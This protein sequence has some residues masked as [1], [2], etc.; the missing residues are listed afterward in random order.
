MKHMPSFPD[1]QPLS[2]ELNPWRSV[3][4]LNRAAGLGKVAT[5]GWPVCA[6]EE[7]VGHLKGTQEQ[8]LFIEHCPLVLSISS[9]ARIWLK[10]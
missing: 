7:A 2:Q 5:P 8:L 4:S 9:R 10:F 3:P 1:S 6:A